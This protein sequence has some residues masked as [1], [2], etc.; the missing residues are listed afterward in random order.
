MS[1]DTDRIRMLNDELR[2]H[3]FGGG[4]VITIGVAALGDDAV[5][6]LVQAVAVF[7]DFC[8]DNDPYQ[9]HDFGAFDFEGYRIMFKIDYYAREMQAASSDPAD[10]SVTERVLTLMLAGEY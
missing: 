10:A 7:D 6:R 8:D 5:R 2:Q 1:L 9:E 3:L 4:A